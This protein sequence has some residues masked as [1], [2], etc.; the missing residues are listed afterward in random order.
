MRSFSTPVENLLDS[1]AHCELLLL[2]PNRP[3]VKEPIRRGDMLQYP[4]FNGG[5]TVA[6]SKS[7]KTPS[8]TTFTMD[9][10]SPPGSKMWR[11][12]FGVFFCSLAKIE[13]LETIHITR[14]R[15]QQLYAGLLL[16]DV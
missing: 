4:A 12:H 16:I 11:L 13:P 3:P 5:Y 10:S 9:G 1:K 14:R 2:M 15:F 8:V 6:V 7:C